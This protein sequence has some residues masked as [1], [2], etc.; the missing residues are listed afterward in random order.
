MKNN[1]IKNFLP[2]LFLT[3]CLTFCLTTTAFAENSFVKNYTIF[4]KNE[5]TVVIPAS[6]PGN[7]NDF[8]DLAKKRIRLSIGNPKSVPAGNYT[9]EILNNLGKTNPKLKNSIL[10]NIVSKDQNVRA[11]LDKVITKEVD[12]GFVYKSDAQIAGNKIKVIP[13]PKEIQVWD[14]AYPIAILQDAQNPQLAK[15]FIR[16]VNSKQGQAVLEK[17]GFKKGPRSPFSYVKSTKYFTNKNLTI[18]AAASL[19]NAFT[20]ISDD[21]QKIYGV[22]IKFQFDSSG[23]LKT[24]IKNGAPVDIF[25]SA[26]IPNMKELTK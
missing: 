23:A 9:I 24:K 4:T 21:F 6:N 11:V 26:D 19:K 16:Y 3:L 13:I 17:Y 8:A 25:A 18:Y 20:E 14:V 5:L 15:E 10:A 12:A 1:L 2:S 7:I 22:N